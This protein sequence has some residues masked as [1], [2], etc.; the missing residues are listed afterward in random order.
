MFDDIQTTWDQDIFRPAGRTY[1]D[2]SLVL[3]TDRTDSGCGAA[4][5][6]TGPFYCPLDQKAYVDLT[7]FNELDKRFKAPGDFAQA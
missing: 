1:R 2:T 6:A 7:F 3:F 5:A 4:S